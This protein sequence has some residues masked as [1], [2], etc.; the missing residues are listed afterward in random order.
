MTTTYIS[1]KIRLLTWR[2]RSA[3]KC[4]GHKKPVLDLL[5]QSGR[6]ATFNR[7]IQTAP[8]RLTADTWHKWLPRGRI[9]N[10]ITPLAQKLNSP[11]VGD[12][13]TCRP[14]NFISGTCKSL[15]NF[16]SKAPGSGSG[17][18]FKEILTAF[19]LHY[20]QLR[21]KLRDR[22]LFKRPKTTWYVPMTTAPH[23]C[24]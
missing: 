12:D 6:C 9:Y 14:V 7:N 23:F 13:T 16:G 18:L 1:R 11:P 20:W 19:D 10:K 8:A 15:N 22:C 24:F 4:R 3:C 5:R 21:W 2:T 17:M